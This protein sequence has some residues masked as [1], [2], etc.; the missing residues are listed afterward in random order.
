MGADETEPGGVRQALPG[1][2]ALETVLA[3]PVRL[4]TLLQ[5]AEDDASAIRSIS[6]AFGLSTEQAET[7]LHNQFR[8]LVRGRRAALAED[9]RILRAPWGEPLGVELVVTGRGSA[10][11]TLDGAVHRFTARGTQQLL[12]Q[13]ADLLRE[14]VVVPQLRPVVLTT[15]MDVPDPVRVHIW[16]SRST[17]FEYADD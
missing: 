7:V 6:E 16:P 11:L 8:L 17:R 2:T 9:L 13:V 10:E 5:E 12:E 15:G 4:V 1:L 3:D 14:R